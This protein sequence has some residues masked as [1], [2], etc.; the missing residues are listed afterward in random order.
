MRKKAAWLAGIL[1]ILAVAAGLAG[2]FWKL[3]TKI[4]NLS[5]TVARMQEGTETYG[6]LSYIPELHPQGGG[7]LVTQFGDAQ[8]NQEMCY[9]VTTDTGLVI[10]DGGWEY[11]EPRLRRIMEQYGN[12]VEAWIL[13]HPHPDHMTAFLDIYQDLQGIRINH[14]Y[15]PEFPELA[16]LEANASWD[17]YTLLEQ[18]RSLEIGGLE[19]LHK[20]DTRDILGLKLE[21]LSAYDDTID[22]LSNDLLN[23]GSLM[24][25]LSGDEESILFC[26][27][28]G[29]AGAKRADVRKRLT[30]YFLSE[31]GG[32]LKS[33]YV[34][35]AHHGFG[36]LD[37]PFY[38]AVDPRA[39]FFDAP[40]WLMDGSDPD[41]NTLE[42][43]ALI[44]DMG[45]AGFTYYTAPN[46]ILLR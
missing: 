26:A 33:D 4:N 43:T 34:Q 9:T 25:R 37:E 42:K 10:I 8:Q 44:R 38:R 12:C 2:V 20:G 11:E 36:G 23:D 30:D 21:V 18:F 6:R 1:L 39:S 32:L 17:D 13:T 29:S 28:V 35:M 15:T 40:A 31:Y 27:D 45:K 3:N 41:R 24:F 7:W 22:E 46:Q 16:T 14:V 5:Q 19:Y